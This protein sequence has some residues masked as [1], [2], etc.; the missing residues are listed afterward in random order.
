[1]LEVGKYITHQEDGKRNSRLTTLQASW[2]QVSPDYLREVRADPL[3][4]QFWGCA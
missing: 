4:E 2:E 1:M 3:G